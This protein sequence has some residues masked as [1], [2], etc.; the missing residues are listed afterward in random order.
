MRPEV[1]SR[2]HGRATS[3]AL[4]WQVG[5]YW[6]S[7]AGVGV[8]DEVISGSTVVRV[9]DRDRTLEWFRRVLGLEPAL[10]ASDGAG[11]PIAVYRLAG[12]LFALWQ[13]SPGSMRSRDE[14]RRNSFLSFTHL[15]PPA[16]HAELGRAGVDVSPLSESEHHSFFYF[17]DPDGNRYE[18]SPPLT[19][20]YD[21]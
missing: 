17:Y 1:S 14:N 21:G 13:L 9:A 7:P 4:R 11:H 18:I 15:D 3:A 10:V 8:A 12:L 5:A 16:V 20:P 19:Q 6:C 2:S